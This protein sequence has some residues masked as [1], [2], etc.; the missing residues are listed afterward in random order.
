MLKSLPVAKPGKL[1]RLGT[2]GNCCVLGGFQDDWGIYSYPLYQHF[3]DHTPEFSEMAAFQEGLQRPQRAPRRGSAAPAEPYVGEFVSGNYFATL[4]VG[5]F[6]GR[7]ITPDDDKAERPCRLAVMSY[8]TWQQHFGLDP[9]VIGA[10]LNIN[11]LAFTVIGIAP[12]GFF[13]DQ[14]RPDPR[15]F[16]VVRWPPSRPT[17]GR[18]ALL[19]QRGNDHWLYII[20]RLKPGRQSGERSIR[21]SPHS[22]RTG[23]STQPDLSAKDFARKSRSS[24]SW[25]RPP[26]A[27]AANLQQDSAEGL[28]LLGDRCRPCAAHRLRQHCEPAAGRAA[29]PHALRPPFAW[30]WARHAAG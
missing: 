7:A 29:P 28:H 25:L 8:R 5:A 30:R 24:T 3:R 6:A 9:S 14:L 4:G 10:T 2:N 16:L 19:K 21:R 20:G 12:P 1:Y 15:R 27:G 22:S 17:M 18:T 13:G 23:C 11:N 26:R